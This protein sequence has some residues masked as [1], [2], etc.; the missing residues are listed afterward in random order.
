MV[1]NS[2]LGESLDVVT[3]R[4]E[5]L[6]VIVLRLS[7]KENWMSGRSREPWVTMAHRK[8]RMSRPKMRVQSRRLQVLEAPT[9]AILRP[10]TRVAVN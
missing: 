9:R 6:R 8:R 1:A 2:E 7:P 10:Q 3:D 4:W 5:R